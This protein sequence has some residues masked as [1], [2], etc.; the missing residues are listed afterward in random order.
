MPGAV[1]R[2]R[3]RS[4]ASPELFT[5]SAPPPSHSQC[6][7]SGGGTPGNC[8]GCCPAAAGVLL[9]AEPAAAREVRRRRRG[10]SGLPSARVSAPPFSLWSSSGVVAA[11]PRF[12]SLLPGRWGLR[13]PGAGVGLPRL[14]QSVCGCAASGRRGPGS[15]PWGPV[16]GCPRA[17]APQPDVQS[18]RGALASGPP[19]RACTAPGAG[20]AGLARPSPSAGAIVF[21]PGDVRSASASLTCTPAAECGKPSY[22]EKCRPGW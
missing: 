7:V 21:P 22:R 4:P 3:S 13:R 18:G 14:S 16:H 19:P 1:K 12:L 20:L 17:C 11:A 2:G 5:P 9:T 6:P 15:G 10:R 8:C